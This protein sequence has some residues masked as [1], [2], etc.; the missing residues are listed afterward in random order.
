MRQVILDTETTGLNANNG[1]RVIEIGCLEM[2]N[3][4]LTGK[5]FH[6]YIHPERK[7]DPKAIEIHGITDE[8]LADKP[9]FSAIATDFCEFIHGAELIIH[10]APFDVGFLNMELARLQLDR[11]NKRV[12]GV[13]DTLADARKMFPGKK[14]SLDILCDR[15]GINNSHRTLHGALLDAELLAEVYLAMTRGQNSLVIED[16]D[17]HT[18]HG[19]GDTPLINLS[20]IVL[21]IIEPHIHELAAHE[22][23]LD[24]LDKSGKKPCVWRAAR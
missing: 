8:F 18:V 12:S 1:D 4:R 24:S 23:I 9:V 21:P 19:A 2:I 10:N 7:V 20:D 5:S 17:N 14:N 13:I 22:A 3:R 11:L 16:E 15:L 6:V